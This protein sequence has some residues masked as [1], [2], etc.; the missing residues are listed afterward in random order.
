MA[1]I[2]LNVEPEEAYFYIID[3]FE[4]KY[5]FGTIRKFEGESFFA[6]SKF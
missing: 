4:C 2:F 5:G 6:V 1:S 3:D